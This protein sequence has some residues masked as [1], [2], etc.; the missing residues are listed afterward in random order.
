MVGFILA[1]CLSIGG[2]IYAKRALRDLKARALAREQVLT[3]FSFPEL[4]EYDDLD[5]PTTQQHPG[6]RL[7]DKQQQLEMSTEANRVKFDIDGDSEGKLSRQSSADGLLSPVK[8]ASG[9]ALVN[10][11][12]KANGDS[13]TRLVADS[14]RNLSDEDSHA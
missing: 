11:D 14:S 9:K 6:S 13:E 7:L 12:G 3:A 1:L 4:E 2:Y 10:G 5:S 8:G